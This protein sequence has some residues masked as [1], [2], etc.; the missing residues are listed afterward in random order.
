MLSLVAQD[1]DF[2]TKVTIILP[3]HNV[4]LYLEKSLRSA[5]AQ[6]VQGL[7]IIVIDDAS[8]DETPEILARFARE[9]PN[10]KP[11]RFDRNVGVSVARNTAINMATGEWIAMF[12]G[13]DWM[14]P[15]RIE[16][17]IAHAERLGV[18][19][20]ADDLYFIR[21]THTE[22]LA[23]L[24]IYE[25]PGAYP[26]DPVHIVNR[27]PPGHHGYG[28]LKPVIRRSFLQQKKVRYRPG[29]RHHGDFLFLIECAVN[30]ARMALWNEAHYWYQLRNGSLTTAD[31]IF[32]TMAMINLSGMAREVARAHQMTALEAALAER[33]QAMDPVLRYLK[34]ITPLKKGK[35][36]TS[37]RQWL[38]DLGITPYIAKSFLDKLRQRL[39]R[40]DP[41]EHVLPSHA[42][43]RPPPDIPLQPPSKTIERAV[44]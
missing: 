40:R 21:E 4:G 38:G 28:L 26:V 30:G 15:V 3:V 35:A 7:E 31:P 32:I 5:L 33:E 34:I 42:I 18:D 25:R 23:R 11:I 37:L 24:M 10:I 12:D 20:I 43:R 17:L 22:P 44:V 39:G 1:S 13:D 14:D 41:I 27:D 29:L 16:M 6:S 8:S 9:Y 36:L 19:W 2:M